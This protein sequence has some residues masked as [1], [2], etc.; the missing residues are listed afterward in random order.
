MGTDQA[1]EEITTLKAQVERIERTLDTLQLN[2]N[3]LTQ[4]LKIYHQAIGLA[5]TI[6]WLLKVLIWLAA[7]T[8][9]Y[10][11]LSRYFHGNGFT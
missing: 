2:L 8:G 10:E 9:A 1:Q 4:A 5:Q 6:T 7:G 11:M 3:D